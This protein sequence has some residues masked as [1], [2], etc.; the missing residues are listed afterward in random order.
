MKMN[1][2]QRATKSTRREALGMLG[3]GLA[4]A[5]LPYVACAQ[6]SFGE[7]AVVRTILK[8]Y[9]PGELGGGASLFHEH[10]SMAP[11]FVLRFIQYTAEAQA[12]N[13]APNAPS[14]VGGGPAGPNPDLSWM[15][16]AELMA[17]ELA[18]AKREGIGCIVDAGTP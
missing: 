11:D 16:D 14:P 3:A 15:R 13:R 6:P 18:I 4:T 2:D 5:A 9:A 12:A 7:G 17:E 1:A 8:D 10:M